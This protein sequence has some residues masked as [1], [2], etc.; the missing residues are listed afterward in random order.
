MYETFCGESQRI[1][2]STLSYGQ[3]IADLFIRKRIDDVL[4]YSTKTNHYI[5]Y[6]SRRQRQGL[7]RGGGGE[8]VGM[9]VCVGG[10]GGGQR[11]KQR[12]RGERELHPDGVSG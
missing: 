6:R 3:L 9:C 4:V 10:G 12:E 11:L 1:V 7:E 8:E 2:K 5:L